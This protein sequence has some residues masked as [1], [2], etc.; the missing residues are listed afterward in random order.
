MIKSGM[1]ALIGLPNAGKSTLLNKLLGQKISIVTPKP[2]TTRN[3]ILGIAND[4]QSQIVFLDTPGLHNSTELLNEVM[5][6]A[7]LAVLEDADLVVLLVDAEKITHHHKEIEKEIEMLSYLEPVRG[8]VLLGI[9]KVDRVQ[10]IELLPLIEKMSALF[11][12]AAVVP[13]SAL[14]GDGVAELR[15]EI[16]NR[17]PFGP[18]FYPDDM[19]TDASERFI[20]SEIIREKIFLKTGQEVPYS[21]AVLIESFKEDE[22]SQ[23]VT[24]HAAIVLEK[25]SQ[26]GIVI[27]KAG[28]RLKAI[29]S[30]AR[31]DIEELLDCRVML[32]LWVKVKKNWT[33]DKQFLKELGFQTKRH[34]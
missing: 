28:E 12:F 33:K 7:A 16:T 32:K 24:I 3:T 14:T 22:I 21:T 19:P 15:R 4:E 29:G 23:F 11:S 2:Q 31:K 26:K 25:D 27:G 13:F 34:N 30:A 10:K 6:N 1:V 5:M 9:N 20:V 18:R 17:L 8:P